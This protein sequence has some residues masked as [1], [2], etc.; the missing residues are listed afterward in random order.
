[1]LANGDPERTDMTSGRRAGLLYRGLLAT[2]AVEMAKSETYDT[3]VLALVKHLINTAPMCLPFGISGR[4]DPAAVNAYA[5]HVREDIAC[6]WDTLNGE[7]EAD[8][9]A[10]NIAYEIL[11]GE[12]DYR[13]LYLLLK[14]R[15]RINDMAATSAWN[16]LLRVDD[17]SKEPLLA[18]IVHRVNATH[19]GLIPANVVVSVPNPVDASKELSSTT[20]NINTDIAD[21]CELSVSNLVKEFQSEPILHAY[22]QSRLRKAKELQGT[23][24]M[25]VHIILDEIR[26]TAKELAKLLE[27]AKCSV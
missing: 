1:M 8:T 15:D 12:S 25:R 11:R 20:L 2:R 9:E 14:Y 4:M 23:S 3:G 13:R 22:V 16:R 6:F 21:E 24:A 17:P 26:K 7:E 10:V 18:C 27:G 19:P 5:A